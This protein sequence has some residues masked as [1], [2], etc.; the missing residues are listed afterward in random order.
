MA[1]SARVFQL[2][3]ASP[4]DVPS[5]RQAITEIIHDWND[6]NSSE[7]QVVVL[8]VRWETHSS[9][10]L[11]APP[12]AIINRQLADQCDFVVS[13]FST[14]MGTPTEN[15]DSGTA[16]EIDR[17]G[18][19]GKPVMLYFS[20]APVPPAEIDTKQ[21]ER[22]REFRAKTY[23]QG[24][25]ED[26]DSLQEFRDKFA[27]HLS[28]TVRNL[29]EADVKRDNQSSAGLPIIVALAEG[30]SPEI[31][32]SPIT[33]Q[34]ELI[35]CT[36]AEDI[37]DYSAP[38]LT[39]PSGS[40]GVSLVTTSA[41]SNRDYYREILDYYRKIRLFRSLRFAIENPG[42][43]GVRDLYFDIQVERRTHDA[44]LLFA[45][46]LPKFPHSLVEYGTLNF[47]QSSSTPNAA[48]LPSSQG[49]EIV[50]GE[51]G[52]HMDLEFPILQPKRTAYSNNTF[53]LGADRTTDVVL[54][55]VI[56]SSSADPALREIELR[57]EAVDV[58][59]T[60]QEVLKRLQ[61]DL[62]S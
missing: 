31:L 43:E 17:A 39:V 40:V 9:P 19:A 42:N 46:D 14:R 50:L 30:Q 4:G 32:P 33:L 55:A 24:I 16:E 15:A 49:R 26:Y 1:Y 20:N 38:L 7:R 36:N 37:P 12:Q 6:L 53:F 62:P 8:P 61:I 60:Y 59:I 3:V 41:G 44:T 21:L 27:R 5:E 35:R 13:V 23:P 57:L 28:R 51:G 29:I 2:L 48:A 18:T 22:V 52:S 10:E 58:E 34:I 45:S 56:Y 25:V 11:G 47:W 54:K